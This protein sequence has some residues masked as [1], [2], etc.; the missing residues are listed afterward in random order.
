M[1]LGMSLM[2]MVQR[3]KLGRV[4]D[5]KDRLQEPSASWN[6]HYGEA[7]RVVE[8]PVLVALV[9]VQLHRPAM[10]VPR[11][12]RRAGLPPNGGDAG[13]HGGFLAEREEAGRGEIGAIARC[14]KL[15]IRA[16]RVSLTPVEP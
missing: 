6:P 7:D 10:D 9:R 2:G 1:R 5:K 15:A 12:I 14:F 16:R 3:R 11:S 13:E 8:D 4:T